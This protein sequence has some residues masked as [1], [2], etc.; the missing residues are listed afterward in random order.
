MSPALSVVPLR[1]GMLRPERPIRLIQSSLPRIGDSSTVCRRSGGYDVAMQS[2]RLV[3]E[4]GVVRP[5]PYRDRLGRH[6]EQTS[7]HE[8]L[9]STNNASRN[10]LQ[11]RHRDHPDPDAPAGTIVK[12]SIDRAHYFQGKNTSVWLIGW[13][14]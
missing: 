12:S 11:E 14:L 2:G 1:T 10:L 3:G 8:R 6:T 7:A 13:K 4:S 9:N 5:R